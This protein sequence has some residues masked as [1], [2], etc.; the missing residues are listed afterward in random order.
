MEIVFTTDK[1]PN[2]LID[3]EA[4]INITIDKLNNWLD[5]SNLSINLNKSVYIQF[6]KIHNNKYNFKMQIPKLKQV[7]QTKFLRCNYRRTLRLES[8]S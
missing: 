3:H 5:N 1:K 7:H 8:S 2:S 6:N 4:D